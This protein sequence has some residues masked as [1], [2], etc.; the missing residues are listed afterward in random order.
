MHS[1]RVNAQHSGSAILTGICRT[2]MP[3]ADVQPS[4]RWHSHTTFSSNALLKFCPDGS[5]YSY[6]IGDYVRSRRRRQVGSVIA[7]MSM[8]A[9]ALAGMTVDGIHLNPSISSSSV[10]EWMV[11]SGRNS[12]MELPL[13]PLQDSES[14]LASSDGTEI[15]TQAEN[16]EPEEPAAER[17]CPIASGIK[18]I[19]SQ[20]SMSAAHSRIVNLPDFEDTAYI[21]GESRALA[22]SLLMKRP[23]LPVEVAALV[24]RTDTRFTAAFDNMDLG[25]IVPTSYTSNRF[26]PGLL[27]HYLRRDESLISQSSAA[28]EPADPSSVMNPTMA[29]TA[30]AALPRS[31]SA[32]YTEISAG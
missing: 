25:E 7:S 19:D 16:H 10:D 14:H 5:S 6:I 12:S 11:P 30:V 23:L 21:S 27:G 29:S 20:G 22:L 24:A 2:Y 15:P 18:D 32:I 26:H 28:A 3:P 4:L 17:L 13:I 1:S 31:H 9:G 8:G